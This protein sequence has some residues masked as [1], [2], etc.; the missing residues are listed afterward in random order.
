MCNVANWIPNH[1]I[2][3]KLEHNLQKYLTEEE[4]GSFC[5]YNTVS[6]PLLLIKP[7]WRTNFS[8]MYLDG[9]YLYLCNLRCP[10]YWCWQKF[11]SLQVV[12]L[13]IFWNDVCIIKQC[14]L[15]NILFILSLFLAGLFL[16]WAKHC[17]CYL[18]HP[19]LIRQKL[20]FKIFQGTLKYCNL[21]FRGLEIF[22]SDQSYHNW[23][24]H[25]QCNLQL[26]QHSDGQL[27]DQS[28][29]QLPL[30]TIQVALEETY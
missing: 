16:I 5:Q 19:V 14:L 9:V 28:T 22:L 2:Q 3:Y 4:T 24:W 11:W 27:W 7:Y 17:D 26:N 25:T 21:C 20:L 10:P 13:S 23:W 15:V 8:Q 1:I 6:T 18:F 12:F 30:P 29:I